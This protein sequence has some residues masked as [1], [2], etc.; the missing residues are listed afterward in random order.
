MQRSVKFGNGHK[1]FRHTFYI[2]GNTDSQI[3]LPF[4]TLDS[5]NP[6]FGFHVTEY[7]EARQRRKGE[8]SIWVCVHVKEYRLRYRYDD[9]IKH[10]CENECQRKHLKITVTREPMA[11]FHS[12]FYILILSKYQEQMT[13]RKGT[14]DPGSL[15]N[16]KKKWPHN[17][18][19]R[20]H[21]S[22]LSVISTTPNL[23]NLGIFN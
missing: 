4:R 17:Q 2:T 22:Q 14:E 20:K 21:L 10:S 5:V 23:F 3:T 8:K 13:G 15:Q 11:P 1:G 16:R 18:L 6:H 9:C 19:K 12:S 7:T